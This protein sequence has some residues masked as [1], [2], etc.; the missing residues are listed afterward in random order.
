MPCGVP[1]TASYRP[2]K[3]STPLGENCGITHRKLNSVTASPAPKTLSPNRRRPFR[4]AYQIPRQP[5]ASG[6]SSFVVQASQSDGRERDESVLVEEPHRIEHERNRD[7]DGWKL[8]VLVNALNCVAGREGTRKRS[9]RRPARTQMLPRQPEHRQRAACNRERLHHRKKQRARPDPEQRDEAAAGTDRHGT[10]VCPAGF[11]STVVDS[12]KCPCSVFQT[13]CTMFPRSGRA[14]LEDEVVDDG[15]EHEKR[16]VRHRP[17]IHG[18]QRDGCLAGLQAHARA[19]K[20]ANTLAEGHRP[21]DSAPFRS[22]PRHRPALPSLSG[23]RR[24]HCATAS[25]A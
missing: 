7:G 4:T 25:A 9:G 12:R 23:A 22:P 6:I 1:P 8:L 20:T 14:G 11:R 5:T 19:T 2:A 21:P 3:G 15:G 17:R 13:A 16:R 10:R 24:E 18:P